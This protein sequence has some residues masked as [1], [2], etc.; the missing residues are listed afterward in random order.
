MPLDEGYPELDPRKIEK[1]E[2]MNL[3]A[4]MTPGKNLDP[5][6]PDERVKDLKKKFF[7]GL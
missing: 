3:D 6:M 1:K 4:R 2:G 5:S 7:P